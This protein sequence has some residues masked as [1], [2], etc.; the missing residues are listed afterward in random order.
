METSA[1]FVIRIQ[2]GSLT[3]TG[4]GSICGQI[5]CEVGTLAFPESHW[6]DFPIV[7]V[8]WWLE[9]TVGLLDRRTRNAD[10]NFMDGP[11]LVHVFAERRDSWQCQFL[12]M[13]VGRTEVI[14]EFDFSPNPF[15][16]SLLTCSGELLH[17]CSAKG[18]ESTDVD[19]V[20]FQRERLIQYV[21]KDR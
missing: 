21:G 16:S 11:Y 4:H 1:D 15:V 12:E 10:V 14:H 20:I 6:Y 18:W 17:E 7:M 13:A 19:S 5:W 2:S 8:K 9:A 3:R